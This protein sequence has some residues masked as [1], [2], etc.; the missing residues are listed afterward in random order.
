ME[1]AAET[2]GRLQ[3]TIPH[4]PRREE[5][6]EWEWTPPDPDFTYPAS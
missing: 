1:G 6:R 3:L 2:H 4:P 5:A